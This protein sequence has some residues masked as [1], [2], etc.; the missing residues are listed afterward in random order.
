MNI[1]R[2]EV[3][4]RMSQSVDANGF[5]FM[6]G[7]VAD[8]LNG[9]IKSQTGCVLYKINKLL[10]N[11]GLDKTKLIDVKI[12]ISNSDDFEQMNEVYEAWIANENQPVRL[13][14]VSGFPNLKYLIEVQAIAVS[15]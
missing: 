5:L 12:Y 13:C 2:N 1:I 4:P 6:A 15:G 11:A 14:L 8:D 10:S 3:T 7:Q 9:D